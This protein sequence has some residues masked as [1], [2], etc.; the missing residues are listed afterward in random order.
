[1]DRTNMNTLPPCDHDECPPTGCTK[2]CGHDVCEMLRTVSAVI[3]KWMSE[4]IAKQPSVSDT[5]I[6]DTHKVLQAALPLLC[7]EMVERDKSERESATTM[8]AFNAIQS[9]VNRLEHERWA[10]EE[11]VREAEKQRAVSEIK[12]R[13]LERIEGMQICKTDENLADAVQRVLT[14]RD[15]LLAQV[16]SWQVSTAPSEPVADKG[17]E[18]TWPEQPAPGEVVPPPLPPA[19]GV[20]PPLPPHSGSPCVDRVYGT[21][22]AVAARRTWSLFDILRRKKH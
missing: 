17:P 1:M 15:A 18:P 3:D 4:R 7:Q 22:P 6:M 19:P 13:D 11:R 14:Q 9:T 16:D 2:I 20:P 8:A 10:M 5:R 21:P 12:L